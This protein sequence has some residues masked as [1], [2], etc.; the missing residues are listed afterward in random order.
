VRR[1]F[2]AGLPLLL[3]SCGRSEADASDA[4][5]LPK[6]SSPTAAP[7]GAPSPTAKQRPQPQFVD[8]TAESGVS[9]RTVCGDPQKTF[10]VESLGTGVAFFDADGDGDQDLFHGNGAPLTPPAD[11]A[12]APR[13]ALFLNDGKGHFRDVASQ[14]GV[15]HP[16]AWHGTTAA[17]FDGD[18][19]PDLLVTAW[20]KPA[21]YRNLGVAGG[22]PRFAEVAA[23]ARLDAA[24][25]STSAAFADLDRDGDLDLYVAHYIVFDPKTAPRDC[26][27]KGM[28]AYCGPEGLTPEPDALYRNEGDGTFTEAKG[29]WGYDPGEAFYALGVLIADL[30][31]DEDPDIYVGNDSQRNLLFRNVGDGRAEEVG[32]GA[33]V[34]YG[35]EGQEQASM[36][37]DA[38]DFDGDGRLDLFVTNFEG[39]YSTLYRNDGDLAFSDVT[40][41]A[42]LERITWADLGWSTRFFDYDHDGDEDLFSANG[43]VYPQANKVPGISYEQENELFRNE[44]GK[45]VLANASAGPGW[46]VKRSFRGAAVGDLDEDGDLDLVFTALDDASTVLRND[47]ADATPWI[48]FLA[49]GRRS[50][51]DGVGALLVLEAGGRRQSK[52]VRANAGYLSTFDA[53]V[54]FGLGGAERADTLSVRWPSGREDSFGP[55]PARRT[56]RLV[57][58]A[59]PE[60]IPR[61]GG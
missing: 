40:I 26:P 8:F 33:G 12:R 34:A 3:A 53:R 32:V 54:H 60:P 19:R 14:A 17:D 47:G 42:G 49:V 22:V 5:R 52:E 13:P 36:G 11:P 39:D 45:F 43:H 29:E 25:W 4:A 44:G 61:A 41:P 37:V 38:G 57:E 2:L 55:L 56:Y 31:G 9:I 23:P 28:K 50:A 7:A 10:I 59:P 16:G 21:L 51:R 18:G 35:D 46:G 6:T 15:D 30:D 1:A 20:G 24:G 58:G 48:R 27:W